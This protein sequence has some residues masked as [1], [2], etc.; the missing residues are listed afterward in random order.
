[1]IQLLNT[2]QSSQLVQVGFGLWDMVELS[3]SSLLF[4]ITLQ[5]LAQAIRT[6]LEFNSFKL[7]GAEHIISLYANMILLKP[8]AILFQKVMSFFIKSEIPL[9]DLQ[10]LPLTSKAGILRK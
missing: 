9:G 4:G 7:G 5:P 1:M 10:I 6:H 2:V 3:P 8:R